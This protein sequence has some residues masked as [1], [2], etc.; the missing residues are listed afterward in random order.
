MRSTIF[1]LLNIGYNPQVK[2]AMVPPMIRYPGGTL[3]KV[4]KW[5]NGT[6]LLF[7]NVK[8]M[9][10]LNT[11]GYCLANGTNAT[12]QVDVGTREFLKPCELLGSE[13]LLQVSILTSTATSNV[14]WS[15]PQM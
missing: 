4:H 1:V 9:G 14:G 10:E 13:P 7:S 5:E 11:R 3:S 2:A 8:V 6:Q 12:Q 15:I